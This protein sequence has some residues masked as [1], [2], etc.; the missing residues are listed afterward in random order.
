MNLQVMKNCLKSSFIFS[1]VV[2]VFCLSF[3]TGV[4]SQTN[5]DNEC[6]QDLAEAR[7]ANAKYHRVEV[8]LAD[9]YIADPVCVASPAGGM[10]IHY[11]NPSLVDDLDLDITQPETLL[12]E[13]TK[14]GRLRLVGVEYFAPV[15]VNGMPWFGPGPPPTGQFNSAPSLFGQTFAGPM[16]GHGPGMPWHYDLHVWL[17]KHNSSGMF[18]EFNPT[19]QCLQ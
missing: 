11:V 15:I 4:L 12:Y 1:F 7:R 3:S 6:Q 5:C 14:N 2:S 18:A 10:G 16:P 17:W 19:V 13:P 8:A 9:G